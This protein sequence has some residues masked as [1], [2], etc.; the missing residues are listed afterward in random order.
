MTMKQALACHTLPPPS[1]KVA[2][3]NHTHTHTDEGSIAASRLSLHSTPL[4]I[5]CY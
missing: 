2:G 1:L 3:I 5:Y 4:N